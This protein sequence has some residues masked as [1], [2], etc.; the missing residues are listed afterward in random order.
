M[1]VPIDG[2]IGPITVAAA[3]KYGHPDALIKLLNVFQGM[4][5]L[6]GAGSVEEVIRMIRA[7]GAHVKRYLRGWLRRV[8]L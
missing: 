7:R 5:Y 4:L 1:P 8:E 3:N 2:V 6:V